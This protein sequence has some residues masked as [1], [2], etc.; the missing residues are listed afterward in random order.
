MR[1]LNVLLLLII[2]SWGCN[3]GTAPAGGGAGKTT[4]APGTDLLPTVQEPEGSEPQ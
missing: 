4:P 3:G 2:V 1:A